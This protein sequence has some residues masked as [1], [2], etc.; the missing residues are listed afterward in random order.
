MILQLAIIISY[1]AIGIALLLTT[2]R[3]WQGPGLPDRIMS[4]D[5]LYINTV[6]LL[7]VLGIDLDS[8]VFFEAALLIAL[9]GFIGTIAACKYI[10]SG[11]I[12][13]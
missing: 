13:R 4:L 8:N 11:D 3:L 7:V 9:M 5:K 10:V 12:V 1:V 2:W 6:A